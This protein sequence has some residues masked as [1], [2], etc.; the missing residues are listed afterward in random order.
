MALFSSVTINAVL[1]NKLELTASGAWMATLVLTGTANY[2][3]L[4]RLLGGNKH[5]D[6]KEKKAL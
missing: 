3:V 4:G 6:V 5:D 1:V 2:F